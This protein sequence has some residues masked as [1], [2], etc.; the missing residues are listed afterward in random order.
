MIKVVEFKKEDSLESLGKHVGCLYIER[1]KRFYNI[2]DVKAYGKW[3]N[4]N[5]IYWCKETGEVVA[6]MLDDLRLIE[7]LKNIIGA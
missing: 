7:K 6:F 3:M 2:K 4:F 1:T 5:P